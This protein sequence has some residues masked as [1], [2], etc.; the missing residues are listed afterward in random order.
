MKNTRNLLRPRRHLIALL[1]CIVLA[2]ESFILFFNDTLDFACA[3]LEN[4]FHFL[5]KRM[6]FSQVFPC[7]IKRLLV[8]MD[9]RLVLVEVLVLDCDVVKCDHDHCLARLIYSLLVFAAFGKHQDLI[10]N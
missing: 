9:C 7:V 10:L 1:S 4:F 3:L 8:S 5:R 6:S 2:C